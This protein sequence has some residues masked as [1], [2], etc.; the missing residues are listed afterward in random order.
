[1]TLSIDDLE[2]T[3]TTK[4]VLE[5]LKI[6]RWILRQIVARGEITPITVSPRVLTWRKRDINEWLINKQSI[7][8]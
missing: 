5:R 8:D 2:D 1:M 4:Q 7:K 3:L 6:S